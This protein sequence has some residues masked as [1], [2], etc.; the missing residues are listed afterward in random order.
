VQGPSFVA[1]GRLRTGTLVPV[2]AAYE[3]EPLGLWAVYPAGRHLAAKV[4]VMVDFLVGRFHG[5]PPWDQ[6]W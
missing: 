5:T 6:G 4:R 2:L 1:G 3:A